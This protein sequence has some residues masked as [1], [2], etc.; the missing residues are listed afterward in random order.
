MRRSVC[1]FAAPRLITL[2][3]PPSIRD[4][5]TKRTLPRRYPL[6]HS[7]DCSCTP[8]RT[9]T[10]ASACD[11]TQNLVK[12]D[13]C[14]LRGIFSDRQPGSLSFPMIAP[15]HRHRLRRTIHAYVTSSGSLFR[16]PAGYTPPVL[17]STLTHLADCIYISLSDMGVAMPAS[18]AW[19]QSD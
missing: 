13:L 8:P 18:Y 17:S 10:S 19:H 4:V 14:R 1:H 15:Q 11:M 9:D 7:L 5:A 2:R 12:P 6:I 3:H 16:F